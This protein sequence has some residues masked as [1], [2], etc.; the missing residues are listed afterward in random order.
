MCVFLCLFNWLLLMNLLPQSGHEYG[1]SPVCN[2]IWILSSVLRRKLFP[3]SEQANCFSPECILMWILWSQRRTKLFP[4][5]VHEKGFSPVCVRMCSLRLLLR[6]NRLPQTV[7][8]KGLSSMCD[9]SCKVRVF[10]RPK[11]LPQTW[12]QKGFSPVCVLMWRVRVL[13]WPKLSPHCVQENGFSPVCVLMCNVRLPLWRNVLPHIEQQNGFSPVCVLRCFNRPLFWAKTLPHSLQT[14]RSFSWII[15]KASIMSS[16]SIIPNLSRRGTSTTSS[17]LTSSC[18]TTETST[19]CLFL[20]PLRFFAAGQSGAEEFFCLLTASFFSV[21][22][23]TWAVPCL[24]LVDLFSSP[25]S[26]QSLPQ[27][28]EQQTWCSPSLLSAVSAEESSQFD[29]ASSCVLPRFD[30]VLRSEGPVPDLS[31]RSKDCA[32]KFLSCILQEKQSAHERRERTC[33]IK[34]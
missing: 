20:P 21:V 34:L 32:K 10:R 4:H 3:H 1:F 22:P 33:H 25:F 8:L 2:L 30:P 26:E 11:L 17:F 24:R 19:L 12:Q 28:C 6:R 7:Q 31:C 16:S 29:F 14:N 18:F 5:S 13:L 23:F 9:L 15:G 27:T